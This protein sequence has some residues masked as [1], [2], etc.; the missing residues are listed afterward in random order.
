MVAR[1]RTGNTALREV[2]DTIPLEKSTRPG[3]CD[4]SCSLTLFPSTLGLTFFAWAP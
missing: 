4:P 1:F 3:G 2:A